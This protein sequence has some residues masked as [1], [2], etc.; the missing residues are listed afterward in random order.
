VLDYYLGFSAVLHGL[1]AAYAVIK[2]PQDKY[3]GGLILIL[4][5]VKLSFAESPETADLIGIRVATEAHLWGVVS[6]VVSGL[7]QVQICK[8]WQQ[9]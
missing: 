5:L 3:F 6:G 1:V 2:L 4:L 7:L 9:S 8:R